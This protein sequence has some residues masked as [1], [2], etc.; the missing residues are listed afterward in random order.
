MEKYNLS[1]LRDLI[2][3][4]PNRMKMKDINSALDKL[5]VDVT[6]DQK[7][8]VII[9]FLVSEQSRRIS[10]AALIVSVVSLVISL[11][12]LAVTFYKG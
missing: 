1:W 4:S 8:E 2:P 10:V 11:A 7:V 12:A 3:E 9:S 6:D 5:W